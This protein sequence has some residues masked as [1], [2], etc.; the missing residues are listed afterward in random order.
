MEQNAKRARKPPTGTAE[1][2]DGARLDELLQTYRNE[3]EQ[4]S[5]EWYRDSLDG[6]PYYFTASGK[7]TLITP[8]VTLFR[9]G[10]ADPIIAEKVAESARHLMQSNTVLANASVFSVPIDLEQS[11]SSIDSSEDE[12]EELRSKT[13]MMSLS[14]N[15]KTPDVHYTISRDE[16]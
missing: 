15:I 5:D 2:W 16:Q 4:P 3:P 6:I 11:T 9:V 12:T 10:P 1:V 13:P 8:W 7:V 14:L